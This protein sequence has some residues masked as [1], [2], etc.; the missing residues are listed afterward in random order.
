MKKFDQ[1]FTVPFTTFTVRKCSLTVEADSE[2]E[3]IRFTM[4]HP[5]C[6]SVKTAEGVTI[7]KV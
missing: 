7:N 3:A 1:S 5:S 6:Q 2:E 4:R